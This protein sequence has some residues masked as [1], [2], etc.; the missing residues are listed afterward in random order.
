[1]TEPWNINIH[2]DALLD[3][4]VPVEA[5]RVLDVGTGD[6]FLAARLAE[7]VATVIAVDIDGPVLE[8]AQA[9]FPQSSVAWVH[10][11]VMDGQFA[12]GLFDAVVSNA[13]LHHLSDTPAAMHRLGSLLVPRG[14]LVS[15][16]RDLGFKFQCCFS[17]TCGGRILVR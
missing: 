1:M 12:L 5:Q 10:D 4:L 7:R 14:T 6:G 9:R 15:R 2:Y 11:D 17:S 8:R 3:S 13:A 16:A